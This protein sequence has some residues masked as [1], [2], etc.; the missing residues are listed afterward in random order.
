M[1]SADAVQPSWSPV[2]SG[3][4][5]QDIFRTGLGVLYEDV[6]IAVIVKMCVEAH[7]PCVAYVDR[8]FPRSSGDKQL[9]GTL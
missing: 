7:T 1:G 3:N 8:S 5:H 2:D 9:V 6:E 4:L